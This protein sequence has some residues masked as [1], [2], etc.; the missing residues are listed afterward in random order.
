MQSRDIGYIRQKMLKM[1]LPGR[2]RTGRPQRRLIDVVEE[3]MEM[4]GVQQKSEG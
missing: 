4:F 3:D 2:M 1:E